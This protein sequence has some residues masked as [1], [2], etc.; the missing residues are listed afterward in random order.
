[1]DLGAMHE[2]LGKRFRPF[3]TLPHRHGRAMAGM[4]AAKGEIGSGECSGV[5][6]VVEMSR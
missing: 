4:V 6:Q 3:G 5:V 1:M 2:S